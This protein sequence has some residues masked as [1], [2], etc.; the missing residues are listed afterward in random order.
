MCIWEKPA[1]KYRYLQ[2]GYCFSESIGRDASTR[3]HERFYSQLK[4]QQNPSALKDDFREYLL[5]QINEPDKLSLFLSYFRDYDLNQ[6]SRSANLNILD[7]VMTMETD[8]YD[9]PT[10]INVQPS[11]GGRAVRSNGS[12]K[13]RTLRLISLIQQ[14]VNRGARV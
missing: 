7:R 10:N 5:V 4:K 12:A 1:T 13:P 3:Y 14:L 6:V 11:I 8:F 2:I 9:D